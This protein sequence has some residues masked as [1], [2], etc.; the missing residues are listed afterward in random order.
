MKVIG[1]GNTGMK[2]ASMF[3]D[4]PILIS[5]AHQDS[6][7]FTDKEVHTFTED[8]AGKRFGTG[9]KIWQ[10]NEVRL[11]KIF[12]NIVDNKVLIF[13][14][15]GGG[16][17][18][19]SVGFLS[20]LFLEQNNQV[21]VV[22]VVPYRKEINPPLAN[23]VQAMNSLL[24]LLDRV[25]VM[26]FDNQK[27]L[28]KYENDWIKVNNHIIQRAKYA[29]SL[30]DE[31]SLDGYSPLTIDRSEHLS[32][33]FGGGFI[34]VSDSFL[35]DTNPK[36]DYGKI[37]A[38]TKNVLIAMFIDK[39]V[40]DKRVDEYHKHLTQLTSKIANRAK[41]ARF[42]TGIMRGQV[43]WKRLETDDVF[44]RA[45]VTIASGVGM[46]KYIKEIEKI[47]DDAMER[48]SHYAE[49][50]KVEKVIDKK[51]EKLLDI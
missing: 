26:V 34:E 8:G 50:R 37:D 4:K 47:R 49:K 22:G 2:F 31:F 41:N 5:T 46:E 7:N 33:I 24:P 35:E 29:V 32:V 40:S 6:A 19:S 27:L 9:L 3:D 1:V 38:E 25:S 36:F 43:N 48:A 15:F 44:D 16:S 39:K 10:S 30:I 51:S 14:S 28:K 17:G 12:E 23:A 18:S 11:K 20:E 21:L 13:S 42:I 45:Y